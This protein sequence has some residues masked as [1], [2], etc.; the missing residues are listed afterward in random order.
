[1]EARMKLIVLAV[2]VLMN[3]APLTAKAF[4]GTDPA[5]CE[6]S[7]A[8]LEKEFK[9]SGMVVWSRCI[10]VDRDVKP[11]VDPKHRD[12]KSEKTS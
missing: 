5:E 9:D 12:P 11:Q 6:A 7:R 1:M 3:D 8:R 10:E 2:L 4:V